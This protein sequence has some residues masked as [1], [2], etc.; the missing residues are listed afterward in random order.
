MDISPPIP[1]SSTLLG[2][3]AITLIGLTLTIIIEAFLL[4]RWEKLT[5]DH[6]FIISVELNCITYIIGVILYGFLFLIGIM[7]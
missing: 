1:F 2:W 4:S 5:W 3:F 7:G 6:A